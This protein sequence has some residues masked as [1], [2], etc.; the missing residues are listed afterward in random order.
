MRTPPYR[1][2]PSFVE[3]AAIEYRRERDRRP[4]PALPHGWDDAP[5]N[6]RVASP[7]ADTATRVELV[8]GATLTPEPIAWL[9]D[10]WLAR[11]KA[12]VFGGSPG[13]G[14]T[15]LAL[16]LAATI[17]SGGVWPDGSAAPIGNAVVWSGEDCPRDTLAPRLIAS[18]ADMSKVFFIGGTI[19]RGQARSFDPAR[20][21]EALRN[22]I[23]QAGG[24]SLIVVD[25]LVAAVGGADDHK[26]SAVRRAL[27]PLVDLA[28]SEDAA[29]VGITHFSKGTAGREVTERISGS[30]AFGALARVVMIAAKVPGEEEDA[31]PKRVFMRSKSNIGPDAGGFEYS[32]Q[33]VDLEAFP[34]VSASRI[35][36]GEV[37]EGSAR[38]V[39]AEAE[40]APV[41]SVA[42]GGVRAARV[43]LEGLLASGPMAA[44]AI[45]AEADGS[46][47]SWASVRRAQKA[48][49]IVPAREGFGPEG[50]WL[51]RLP[52]S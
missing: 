28:A 42:G 29:L 45:R 47:L 25:P 31:P 27:Q 15:T 14:K 48:L 3:D 17:T 43:F 26:N 37:I 52:S 1:P 44:D 38:D 41:A 50:R 12:H 24:C 19:E 30:L 2:R 32:L 13:A 9:W 20:D 23:K 49:G 6:L 8:Q 10:G 34:G 40:A 5:R 51:W 46:G 18:G 21:I 22:A 11:G 39:L 35:E 33:Q 4:A 36:W 16:S 7:P